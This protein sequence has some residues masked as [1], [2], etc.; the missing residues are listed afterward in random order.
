[1]TEHEKLMSFVEDTLND[2]NKRCNAIAYDDESYF[3][4]QNVRIAFHRDHNRQYAAL[5][6]FCAANGLIVV[7][8]TPATLETVVRV[9]TNEEE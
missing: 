4:V 2:G 5:L 7:S 6:R 1:M 3:N 9:S 8:T